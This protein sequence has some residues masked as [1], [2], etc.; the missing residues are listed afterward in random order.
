[1]IVRAIVMLIVSTC[2]LPA[3]AQ[4]P[5]RPIRLVVPF[6]SASLTDIVARIAA[7]RLSARLGQQLVVEN[8]VGA[9]GAIGVELVAKAPADGYTMGLITASTHGLAPALGTRLPYDAINDFK[10]VSMIGEAPYVLVIQTGIP[11]KTVAELVAYARTRP[12]QLNYGSAG[13]A[14]VA[15]LAAALLALRS[16]I[17]INHVPYKSTAQSSVDIMA[18]R[19]DMQVAT[20]APTMAGIRDGK[21]RALATTGSRR[22]SAL[23]DVPTMIEAGVKDYTVALWMAFVLPGTTSDAVVQRLN[24]EMTAILNEK[25]TAEALRKQGLEPA[26]GAPGAVTSRIREEIEMWRTLIAKTGI[27]PE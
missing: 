17:D 3:L 4:Y 8:R 2:A 9:S 7:Q 26:P 10:P 19:L 15:H 27:K 20:I 21:L 12:G 1:M 18:G 13:V 16:G 6:P 14:S 22:T 25:E 5:D 24:G 11:A 23:P